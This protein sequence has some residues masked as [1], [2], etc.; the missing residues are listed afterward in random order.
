MITVLAY[1]F[2]ILTIWLA[3]GSIYTKALFGTIRHAQDKTIPELKLQANCRGQ[4]RN[5][6]LV[7]YPGEFE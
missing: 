1:I 5:A 2:A 4:E 3:D 6:G 7:P